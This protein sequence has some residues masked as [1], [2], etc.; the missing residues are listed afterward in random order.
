MRVE[1]AP[2]WTVRGDWNYYGYNEKGDS[3][4]TLPRDFRGNVFT[5]GIK[6]AF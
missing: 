1:L 3:G 5:T 4:P 6:Y 2:R